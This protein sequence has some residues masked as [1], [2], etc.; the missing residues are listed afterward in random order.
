MKNTEQY[1]L[2]AIQESMRDG[3]YEPLGEFLETIENFGGEIIF[4]KDGVVILK[5]IL[6]IAKDYLM[7][8]KECEPR[9]LEII[10]ML[11]GETVK[12]VDCQ[13][14]SKSLLKVMSGEQDQPTA[15]SL[16]ETMRI[17]EGPN[18]ES[19][20]AVV[21]LVSL[22][23]SGVIVTTPQSRVTIVETLIRENRISSTDAISAIINSDFVTDSTLSQT[24]H[25][26]TYP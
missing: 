20:K 24:I 26:P 5:T 15:S 13:S 6:S 23:A 4:T 18:E 22:S 2:L 1:D 19:A 16:N 25:L 3:D 14:F 21:R 9:K 8:K 11:I 7:S 10:G 17:K 12:F